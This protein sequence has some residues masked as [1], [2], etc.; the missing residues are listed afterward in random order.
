MTPIR[1][2]P[3]LTLLCSTFLA[4]HAAA[5]TT[6]PAARKE[7]I[8]QLEASP[9]RAGLA[10]KAR[11]EARLAAEGVPINTQLPAIEDEASAKPRS[12]AE[13][14][15]RAM[16]LMVVAMKGAGMEQA[17]VDAIAGR[18]LLA[19]HFTPDESRFLRDPAPSPQE[20]TRFVWR[21][22]AAWTL[23]WALGYVDSLAKPAAQ[24]DVDRA[25]E[26]MSQRDART[27]VDDAKLRPLPQLLDEADLIY[28][29][30]WAVVDARVNGQGAPAGLEPGVTLERHHA[31]NWLIGYMDQD[32]DE[33]STD[34]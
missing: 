14:A 30:H 26:L 32:W 12:K 15:R 11:S 8:Q 10:R 17:K 33:V 5:E 31:L 19:E 9:S 25:M 27:F 6:P 21:V 20:S 23:M 18:Y 1:A 34:T 29:Y 16:A 28:R 7:R 13:V 22:E 4:P 3:I 24:C 2:L